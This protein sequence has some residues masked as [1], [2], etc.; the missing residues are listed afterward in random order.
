MLFF[1]F[2]VY[3]RCPGAERTF[4]GEGGPEVSPGMMD[5]DPETLHLCSKDTGS[6][7]LRFLG[8]RFMA[9]V[10]HLAMLSKLRR[11][12]FFALRCRRYEEASVYRLNSLRRAVER[13]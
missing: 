9:V 11:A 1:P 8:D 13:R 6:R 2:F 7:D 3:Q 4:F 12:R 5:L 10:R